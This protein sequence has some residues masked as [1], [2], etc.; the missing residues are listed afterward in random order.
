VHCNVVSRLQPLDQ[1]GHGGWGLVSAQDGWRRFAP[2][3]L[4]RMIEAIRSK[5]VAPAIRGAGRNKTG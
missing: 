3:D 2:S 1:S 4:Q 5:Q